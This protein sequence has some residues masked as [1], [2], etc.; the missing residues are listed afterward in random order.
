[1]G[2]GLRGDVRFRSRLVVNFQRYRDR[3]PQNVE[4]RA[5]GIDDFLQLRQFL[6]AGGAVEF[7]NAPNILKAGD[8][9]W[10]QILYRAGLQGRRLEVGLAF[11]SMDRDANE[12]SREQFRVSLTKHFDGLAERG[13]TVK[14]LVSTFAVDDDDEATYRSAALWMRELLETWQRHH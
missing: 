14:Y 2:E 3:L 4:D 8:G 11:D 12:A 6:L 1:M 5:V 10:F 13:E 9:I 7:D